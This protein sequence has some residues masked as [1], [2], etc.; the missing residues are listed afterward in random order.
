MA[1]IDN[2]LTDL[3]NVE[4][5]YESNWVLPYASAYTIALDRYQKKLT[6]QDAH[7]K[8]VN[9]FKAELIMAALTL[10]VGGGLGA[11]FGKASMKSVVLDKALKVVCD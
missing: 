10:G 7:N 1:L 3:V 11:M 5:K 6:E 2:Y 9:Q 4:R 8:A